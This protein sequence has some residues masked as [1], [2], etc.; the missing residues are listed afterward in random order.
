MAISKRKNRTGQVTGYQVAVSVF[1][2]K[3]GKIVRSVVGSFTRRKDADRAERAAKV[4]V[5]NGTFELE[6]LEPA[7]VWTVGAVVAGWLTGHRATVTANTYSQYESAY[8]LHLK[9]A[10][11]D[12]DITGL[13]RADIKAVLRLW[14]AAGMGAQLQNR[15]M[16]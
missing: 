5:E 10:L 14:Q 8:R 12:C 16:L 3:A 2:P 9:D 13:T 15:A 4:A 11:G 7:K 1:D 6:P